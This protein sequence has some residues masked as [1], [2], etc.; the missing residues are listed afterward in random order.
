MSDLLEA[1]YVEGLHPRDRRGRWRDTLHFVR[2][3]GMPNLHV[4]GGAV[5]DE[6]LG[7]AP[8]DHDFVVIGHGPDQI[9]E[10][11]KP[12]GRTDDLIVAGKHV[13]VRFWP[14]DPDAQK[15]APEGIEFTPP[16]TEVSTGP[17]HTDFEIK[18]DASVPFHE[19]ALRRDFTVNAV[20]KHVDTGELLD[21]LGGAQDAQAGILRV[22]G[23]RSFQDDPLRIVRGLRF[24]SQHGLTPD[25][26]TL[27]QMAEH[28]PSVRHL[29]GERVGAEMNKL[30]MGAEPMKALRIARDTGVLA[31][32]FP[33]FAPVIGFEQE[34]RYH[35]MTAD[36]HIFHVVQA[37][38]DSKVPLR[39]RWA[40]FFHDTGKPESSWLG[41]DGNLHYYENHELGKQAHE[42][43][44]A[45]K[46]A[47]ALDRLSHLA[48]E[49]R[50]R[51]VDIVHAHM[52]QDHNNPDARRARRFLAKHGEPLAH[53][54][55]D[56]KRAD[57]QGKETDKD[58]RIA[59]ELERLASF[60][61]AVDHQ[62]VTKQPYRVSD[63][64]INGGDLIKLGYTQGPKIGAALDQLAG[65]VISDPALNNPAWLRKEALRMLRKG[66]PTR[67]AG[68]SGT[69]ASRAAYEET[70]AMGNGV[71]NG[72]E[73]SLAAVDAAEHEV[74]NYIAMMSAMRQ[75]GFDRPQ[76]WLYAGQE[77]TLIKH[78]RVFRKMGPTKSD[79][80]PAYTTPRACYSNATTLALENPDLTYVEG[81]AQ[82]PSLIPVHHAWLVDRKGFVHDPTWDYKDGVVYAGIPF[83]TD[84]VLKKIV[85]HE[86]YGVLDKLDPKEDLTPHV[87][88]YPLEPTV[89][90]RMAELGIAAE[91]PDEIAKALNVS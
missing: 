20:A 9:K 3:L 6:L 24:V 87:I 77:D 48:R 75:R 69:A 36:E 14:S 57:V 17:G 90:Q 2:S 44:G 28:A 51:V 76:G 18:A 33:E 5:R 65:N 39:V 11:L 38:A 86:E 1:N 29:S 64:A 81:W 27:D 53:D 58:E 83:K 26:G 35:G 89:E 66:I 46:A 21:P 85:K 91:L 49:D 13:G 41:P 56:M 50:N 52:Y 37:M 74:L 63:L 25:Q 45:A 15:L 67:E 40:G 43:I 32:L 80:D 31:Q 72:A 16:R 34:S 30:L 12:H 10:M 4:V 60:E 73:D 19:D 54:L 61:A 70:V 71:G 8:K 59:K 7:K 78:G 79:Y 68:P 42:D 88:E 55:I 62:L 22:I 47:T 82:P 23:P 84:F